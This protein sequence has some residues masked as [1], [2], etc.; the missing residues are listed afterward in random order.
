[1]AI[2]IIW[3]IEIIFNFL[4][5]NNKDEELKDTIPNYLTG[6]FCFDIIATIPL[7]FFD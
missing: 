5:V 3:F 7:L 6:F 1:M 4:K 2:D